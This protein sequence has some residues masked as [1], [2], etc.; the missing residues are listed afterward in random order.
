M[1][2]FMFYLGKMILC[3][4]VMFAYYLLFLK[5]KTFHHYN[6]FYL[7]LTVII[8]LVLP[9]IKVSYFT[10]E[11]NQN[12]YLLL[13]QLNQNQLQK[14]TN[15]LTI[16]QILYAIIGVVSIIL[17]VILILGITKIQ[18]IK[19]K[20]PNE[21]IEGIKFYQ[22]NLNN[23]PFSFF[24]NLF[25]KQSIQL[26]SPVGQQILKHEMVHIQQ[27]HSWDKLL[28]QTVKSVFWFNPV[29]YFINKEINLI[30]EYLADDKAVKKADTRAFAQMLLESHFSGSVIP[31][32]S[33]FLS[34]NLK[35]RLKMLTKNQTKYSYTR[36][37]FALPILFFMVFAY[38]VNA[39][40]KEI[41]ET[42]KA[43]EIAVNEL[44]N[45]TIKPQTSELDSLSAEHQTQTRVYSEALQEDHLKMSVISK[46]MAEKGKELSALKKA[47]KDETPE[48]K[49]LEKD[50]ETLAGQ[51]ENIV[52]SDNYKNNI[53]GLENN[54]EAVAKIYD[55]PEFKK[56]IAD[57]E[58][59][60]K[61][62]EA[63]YN[64]PKFKKK[65]ADVEKKAKETEAYYNSSEFKKKIADV[66]KKAKETEAFYNSPEFKKRIADAEKLAQM[67]SDN[68][69]KMYSEAEFEKMITDKYG[70]DAFIDGSV[71]YLKDDYNFPKFDSFNQNF[72]FSWSDSGF[73]SAKS[74]LSPKELKKL[75]KKRKEL[76]KKQNELLEEQKKLQKKQQELNKEARQNNPWAVTFNSR[77]DQLTVSTPKKNLM[78]INPPRRIVRSNQ[79]KREAAQNSSTRT[80]K[81]DKIKLFNMS[82][83]S[84]TSSFSDS[85]KTAVFING[86]LASW[87]EFDRLDQ[88]GI[89]S[90]NVYK[91]NRVNK[92]E[93]I[94]K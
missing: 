86:K 56:R 38:M 45:D 1:E 65:I 43:I 73:D 44:K 25:W 68:I 72:N 52:T 34:S 80:I 8:S 61:E 63:Y 26:D 85:D 49:A 87:T 30:H 82:D 50:L 55:S 3:S 9:L 33:P 47:K 12:F 83:S 18:S 92:V 27:K 16:Y 29:F 69:G 88:N 4:G 46:K 6:R 31:V 75:E 14:S 77:P 81:A 11:T 37:L 28:M 62:T 41:T 36:K 22:T 74:N 64:S 24:R 59:K 89:A 53:K 20:F 51:M 58:K 78:F 10:I 40:N 7:L 23:A 5:D 21:T 94:T 54:A 35:K 93:V 39:K 76:Q 2:A 17:L 67:T 90:V 19:N 15:D 66:E 60:A 70:K 71:R 13:S 48:Y 84:N 32:T 42:N 57:V 91:S 79:D